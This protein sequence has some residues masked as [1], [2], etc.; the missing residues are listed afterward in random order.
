LPEDGVNTQAPYNGGRLF[1][2]GA[3]STAATAKASDPIKRN[4]QGGM[5]SILPER[6]TGIGHYS[7]AR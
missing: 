7:V 6:S 4:A 1:M 3:G 2:A 5:T